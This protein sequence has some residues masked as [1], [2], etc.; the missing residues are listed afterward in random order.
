MVTI[1][2]ADMDVY[3]NFITLVNLTQDLRA[4]SDI[5]YDVE[6][7]ASDYQDYLHRN[8]LHPQ[9]DFYTHVNQSFFQAKLVQ[10]LY[11]PR[12]A[13]YKSQF[14]YADREPLCGDLN[15]TINFSF[16]RFHHFRFEGPQESIPSMN[17]VKAIVKNVNFTS[18]KIFP[19]AR[20]YSMWETDE[21]IGEKID[22]FVSLILNDL[23][24]FSGPAD[25]INS[26]CPAHTRP[27][28]TLARRTL[29]ISTSGC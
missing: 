4:Q 5:L 26:L 3:D 23:Q 12:G 2:V 14:F 28:A 10:F 22:A 13:K 19:I 27:L 7:W 8:F 9:A 24:Y 16:L 11:S 15:T 20:S 1:N 29:H 17:R 18:G 21:V 25:P 6:S